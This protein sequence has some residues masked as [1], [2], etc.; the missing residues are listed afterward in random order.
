MYLCLLISKSD[1]PKE[2]NVSLF[3]PVCALPD[4]SDGVQ[5]FLIFL[6]ESA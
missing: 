6:S 1:N 5:V 4:C 2:K 3:K